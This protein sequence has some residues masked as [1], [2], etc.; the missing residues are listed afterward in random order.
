MF[1][2]YKKKIIT[3]KDEGRTLKEI[4]AKIGIGSPQALRH[5]IKRI[6]KE[7]ISRMIM[8]PSSI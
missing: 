1:D 4:I 2:R 7:Q 3:L 5:Y 6:E 8:K